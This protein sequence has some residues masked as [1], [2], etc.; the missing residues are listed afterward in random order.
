MS[1]KAP[2]PPAGTRDFL[3]DA[4]RRRRHVTGIIARCFERHGYEPLETPAMERLEVLLGKYGEEGDKLLFKVLHRG[5]KLKKVLENPPVSESDLTE[6]GL[7]YDLTVPLARVAANYPEQLT[8]IFKRYQI[9]PVWRADRPAK[10]RFRE[11]FQC[12][13]DILGS[14]EILAELDIFCAIGEIMDELGLSDFELH[15]NHRRWLSSFLRALDIPVQQHVA[16]LGVLDKMDKVG[17]DAVLSELQE[18]NL[19]TA[20]RDHLPEWFACFAAKR[21]QPRDFMSRVDADGQAALNDIAR[22]LDWDGPRGG[23]IVWN[24]LLARGLDYYTGLIYELR[25]P[26]APSSFGGGGRYDN[27]IGMFS[28]RPMPAV[29]FSF[30]LERLLDLLEE[31]GA[32]PAAAGHAQ[33]LAIVLDAAVASWAMDIVSGLRA[34]GISVDLYPEISGAVKALKWADRKQVRWALFFGP[35][36]QERQQVSWKDLSTG[37][38]GQS[39][40]GDLASLFS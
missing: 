11:F 36:E 5:E 14:P 31:R 2:L 30:G 38:T 7:R 39:A 17:S 10:G 25:I 24:P 40:P 18:K 6:L 32:L 37:A 34:R 15:L 20:C 19:S 9:Q 23:R 16:V 12:D 33:A 1:T 8:R 28:G 27:L 35:D 29:G 26:P 4:V 21:P 22:V 3:P 13:V